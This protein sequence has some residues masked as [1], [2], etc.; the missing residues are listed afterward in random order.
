MTCIKPIAL[1]AALLTALT[2]SFP[3]EAKSDT[4]S[5]AEEALEEGKVSNKDLDALFDRLKEAYRKGGKENS[6]DWK[7]MSSVIL[8][9]ILKSDDIQKNK[10]LKDILDI[11]TDGESKKEEPEV[12]EKG[13]DRTI[14]AEVRPND[15]IRRAV[16]SSFD[17]PKKDWKTTKYSYNFMDLDHDGRMEALVLVQGP[18]TS[19]TG[20][21]TLLIL[22]EKDEGWEEDQAISIVHAPILVAAPGELDL[23]SDRKIL[24]LKRSGGGA[25]EAYVVLTSHDGKYITVGEAEEIKDQEIHGT[26]LLVQN[27]EAPTLE[28]KE[29]I[30]E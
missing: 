5:S 14:D 19:G 16:I 4:L 29:K 9:E 24:I 2:I 26:L 22:K 25:K 27:E 21:D 23:P 15:A 7:G 1:A 30:R 3:A 11:L 18:Y 28:E 6:F 8:G 13:P 12:E 10:K 17:I 20:G